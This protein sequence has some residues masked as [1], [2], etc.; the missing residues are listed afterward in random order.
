MYFKINLIKNKLGFF[1]LIITILFGSI[2]WG[3]QSRGTIISYFSSILIVIFLFKNENKSKLLNLFLIIVL[4]ILIFNGASNIAKK[5]YL[6][7]EYNISLKDFNEL[8]KNEKIELEKKMDQIKG[9]PLYSNRFMKKSRITSGRIEIWQYVMANYE[10]E[11]IFGYGIQGDRF[12]LGKK[13]KSYGNNSSNVFMYFFI[14]GGYFA[15]FV[16]L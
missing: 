4:P 1:I 13:Y 10:K 2:I 8:S 11:K 12:L 6:K 7:N 5:I 15:I 14:S 3:F 9:D 16:Y